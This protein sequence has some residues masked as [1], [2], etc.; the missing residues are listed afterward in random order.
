MPRRSKKKYTSKQERKAHRI[1]KG[2]EERGVSSKEAQ[3]CACA[4]VNKSDRKLPPLNTYSFEQL[5]RRA[6]QQIE[7]IEA[8]RRS[9]IREAFAGATGLK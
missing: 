7:R 1:E 5:Q 4:T 2:Y 8:N 3:R 9:A 6:E